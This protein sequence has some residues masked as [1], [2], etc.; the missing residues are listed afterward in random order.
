ME[1]YKKE[2]VDFL[3]E[4]G[5]LKFGEFILKSGRKSPYFVNTGMLNDGESIS[6]LAYFYAAKINDIFKDDFDLV[7]GPA[8][9]GIPLSTAITISL[10]RDFN[11]N[12]GY[13]FNRKEPKGHG[14]ASKEEKQKNWI[15]GSKI[16]DNQKIIMVDDVFTTGDTKYESIELLSEIADALTFSGLIIAVDRQEIGINEADAIQQFVEK[17]GISVDSIVKITEIIDYLSESGKL[18]E[19]QKEKLESYLRSYGTEDARRAIGMGRIIERS[20]SIIPACDVS[21]DKFESILR[22]TADVE[23]VGAYK[24]GFFLGLDYGL[25]RVVEIA[26]KHTKKPIIYDHQKAGTDIPDMGKKFAQVC[27]KAGVD[28]VILFPFASPI[29]EYEWIK[30]SQE[31]GLNI[32]VGGRMT[33]PR[34]VEGDYSNSKDKDYTKIFKDLGFDQDI[35]GF[36]KAFGPEEIY[37]LAARMGVTNFVVPGNNPSLAEP[38]INMLKTECKVTP[39]IFS[40]GLVAQGGDLTEGGKLAE[41]LGVEFHGIVGRGIYNAESMRRSALELSSKL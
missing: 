8:Y 6:R 29:T 11:I 13:A 1:Q 23:G 24:I 26:R 28:A 17:T 7:F 37:R 10:A 4:K 19:E 30:A 12:K 31:E 27:K 5:A 32:I 20:K 35:T 38:I 40:P 21:L 34:Q 18:T 36:I 16:T 25:P 15:V 33:H 14:E 9:K 22:E 2:F 3:L 39:A 41:T